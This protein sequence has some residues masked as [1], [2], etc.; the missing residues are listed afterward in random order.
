[1]SLEATMS[2]QIASRADTSQPTAEPTPPALALCD[3][4]G[5]VYPI[6]DWPFCPHGRF[7]PRGGDFWYTDYNIGPEPLTFRSAR[8]VD[9]YAKEHGLEARARKNGGGRWV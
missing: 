8:E 1:M 9:K 3:S 7:Q 5:K 2:T 6:G 4:C